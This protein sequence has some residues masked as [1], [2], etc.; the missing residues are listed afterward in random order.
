MADEPITVLVADDQHL[1]RAGF[2]VILET[3]DD[4]QVVGEAANGREA[5]ALT[6]RLTPT[7]VLMDIRMPVMD[8][9]QAA[10]EIIASTPSKV[11]VLTTFDADEYVYEA[12]RIGASGFLLK[13]AEPEQL[14]SAV[15]IVARG[16]ALIDPTITRRL[17]HAFSLTLQPP[18]ATPANLAGLTPRELEVLRQI[19][20]GLSNREIARELF[21]EESTIRTHVTRILTKLGLRDRVQ[22]VV[23]AYDCGLVT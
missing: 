21:V 16:D 12:L 18:P 9:L 7:L 20:R 6:R 17:I 13:D 3:Q 4:I 15:R 2:R 23:L 5:V 11:L 8:G 14:V 22:A 10:A 1:V 19:A